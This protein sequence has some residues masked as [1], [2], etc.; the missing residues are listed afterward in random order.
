[1]NSLKFRVHPNQLGKRSSLSFLGNSLMANARRSVG[2]ESSY[3]YKSA[4][5]IEVSKINGKL[6]INAATDIDLASII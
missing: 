3:T 4:I 2:L 6:H 1:M 5:D